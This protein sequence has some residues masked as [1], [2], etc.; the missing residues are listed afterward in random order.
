MKKVYHSRLEQH[1]A[2]DLGDPVRL[3]APL[4]L[5]GFVIFVVMTLFHPGGPANDHRVIFKEYAASTNWSVIHLGQ[6]VGVGLL[7]AGLLVL[8]RALDL[9]AGAAAWTARLGAVCAATALGLYAVLQA[10]DGVA[11][12]QAVD[13]WVSAPAAEAEARFASAEVIRWVE[14]G[15]RSYETLMLGS[16]LILLG[17]AVALSGKLPKALG[18]L[19]ALS[20]VTY[21]VQAWVLGNAGFTETNTW[22]ILA[23]YVLVLAWMLWLV[24]IA[25]RAKQLTEKTAAL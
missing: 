23:G 19:M 20:G 7:V 2:Y 18:Y 22:A 21:L 16:A 12:K 6:F 10:V 5:T 14:W 9:R 8:Y 3:A 17:I 11:L 13:T 4:L 1:Q 24:V 25:W 15:A